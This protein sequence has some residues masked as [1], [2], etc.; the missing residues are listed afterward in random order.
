MKKIIFGLILI[1]TFLVVLFIFNMTGLS[2]KNLGDCYDTD[3]GLR[4]EVKGTT[5]NT[6]W[7]LNFTDY[8]EGNKLL[9]YY[10]DKNKIK[11]RVYY[12]NE[13]WGGV[14]K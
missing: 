4:P 13:C 14:C 6:N 3:F 7:D 11:V 12:C 9:E 5:Y 2:V 10:C 1:L 8:C